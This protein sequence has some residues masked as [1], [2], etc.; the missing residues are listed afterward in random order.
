MYTTK[1][2]D[3][4]MKLKLIPVI[5]TAAI[6]SVCT[7]FIAAHYNDR[8]PYI[9]EGKRANQQP[10]NYAAYTNAGTRT[11]AVDFTP[12]AEA[13]VKAVV[14]IKTETN[15]KQVAMQDPFYDNDF[16]G[17]LFGQRQYYIPK[18]QGSGSGVVISPDGYIVT[19]N[20]VVA[21]TDKVTVTFND[22]FTTEAKV[23]STDPSTDIA[24]L[25]VNEKSLPYM[26]FGNSD[27]VRLGQW[28]LAVGYP[29]TLE[30]T[31]TAGIVSAKG[32]SIGI[33][34][35]KSATAIESFIQTDAAV[36]PGNSG[37]A[38]VNT[39]GQLIGI[40]SAIA[41]PT[42]SYAG[43]SYAVPANLV[44][45]VVN[46][47][48][49]YGSVQRGY[50]GIQLI[51]RKQ[52]TQEQLTKMGI[53]RS[54]G[55]Y[56]GGVNSESGAEKA[57]LQKGDFITQVNGIPVHSEPE[58][59]EQV[60]RYKP[61]DNISLTYVR[62]GNMKTA[63]VLLK[64]LENTTKVIKEASSAR[65]L[66]A[67]FR[68]LSSEEKRKYGVRGGLMVSDIGKGTLARQTNMKPGFVITQVND[69]IINS[70]EDLQNT[71][72]AGRGGNTQIAGFYPGKNGMYY[73]GLS[74]L[75]GSTEN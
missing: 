20:H 35:T 65:L 60:A 75:D 58:L 49:Q 51:D 44:R 70:V 30:A 42:G 11:A 7:L 55:I 28:V 1:I 33:N 46:D 32:R 9:A 22:R 36:N 26:E 74:G 34:K 21:G 53:D 66:G 2:Q 5:L 41:S 62:N 15:A 67:S 16:F 10:V 73:F 71:L 4:T 12:A 3:Q 39:D 57:G 38:L 18:Q 63:S 50:L 52:L 48:M 19:N 8:I 27:D 14:H 43:Y 68:V 23:I 13:S 37:G 17:N 72:S 31:V 59:Q 47:L 64:N 61:G 24:V 6:T 54:D 29:L 56:V 45:K 40:N 25:K 69:N